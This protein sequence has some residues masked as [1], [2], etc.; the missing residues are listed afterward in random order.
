M[1][2]KINIAVLIFSAL[3]LSS[4]TGEMLTEND[5]GTRVEY[6]IGSEFQVQL[7]GNP[8]EGFMWKTVGLNRDVVR[9]KGEPV[10]QSAA[11]T[12]GDYGTYTFTFK[13]V[14][15][16]NMVLRLMYYDKNAEDPK[17]EKTIEIEV[18]SGTMGRIQ[19]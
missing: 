6:A 11:E 3:L 14:S 13:T 4:C 5:N 12:G 10:I 18:I 8:E 15:A 9:Q 16:G 19:S 7:K 2:S 17:P 1:K